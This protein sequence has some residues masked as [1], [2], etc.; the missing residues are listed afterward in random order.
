[1]D[2]FKSH[3]IETLRF[4][5]LALGYTTTRMPSAVQHRFNIIALKLKTF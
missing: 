3:A 4:Q 5:T 2:V 1:M